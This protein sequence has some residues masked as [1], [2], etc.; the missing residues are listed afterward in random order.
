MKTTIL[1]IT[2]LAIQ[3]P[4]SFAGNGKSLY[5]DIR[6]DLVNTGDKPLPVNSSGISLVVPVSDLRISDLAPVTPIEADFSDEVDSS[7]INLRALKPSTPA[8]ADFE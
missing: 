1:I 3:I 7:G 4:F 6:H 2:L 8:E 5:S